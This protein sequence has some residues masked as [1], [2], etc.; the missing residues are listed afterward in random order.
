[1]ATF[2]ASMT[3]PVSGIFDVTSSNNILTLVD[4]SNY[5]D[6]SPEDG[7]AKSD[8][9]DFRKLRITLP[10]KTEYLFSSIGDGDAVIPAPSETTLP[11]DT[12]YPYDTGDGQYIIDLYTLPTWNPSTAYT[13]YDPHCVYYDGIM[14]K[15]LRSSTYVTPLGSVSYWEAVSDINNLP[16][17]YRV[18]KRIVVTSDMR[19]LRDRLM[20]NANV[21]GRG[22][23]AGWKE[24]IKDKEWIDALKLDMILN[25]IPILMD[26]K[27][28][29]EVDLM[30]AFS[31]EIALK[32]NVL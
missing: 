25:R 24:I 16:L 2:Q 4:H 5:G 18:L 13:E 20:Y 3:N 8:F 1:M 14:Y 30:V 9:A 26:V 10:D 21:V 29:T 6:I 22:I 19:E 17:K 31:K 7:H 11:I 32:H 23:G 15:A 28:W 27:A 12:T